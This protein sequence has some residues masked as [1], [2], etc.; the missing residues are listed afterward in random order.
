MKKVALI[1]TGLPRLVEESKRYFYSILDIK[2][3]DVYC[4]MWK[5]QEYK[6]M[7]DF[8]DMKDMVFTDP[9]DFS[10]DTINYPFTHRHHY[11]GLQLAA[12]SFKKYLE[13]SNIKYDFIIRSRIDL[14]PRYDGK[15]NF[16]L[17]S[18]DDIYTAINGWP[19][20]HLFDDCISIT[21]QENYFKIYGDIY[22]Y[23]LENVHL[24]LN[25]PSAEQIL[26]D[27]VKRVGLL[28]SVR[29][30]KELYFL[31]TRVCIERGI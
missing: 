6:L 13:N 28:S 26:H 10:N 2:N 5:T 15:I 8:A 24:Y 16:D 11:Y 22:D 29:K 31:L 19:H 17:L 14:R 1:F 3:I 25:T 18:S 27:Q 12:T 7:E 4:Y 21:S 9:I 20:S 30:V 23:F